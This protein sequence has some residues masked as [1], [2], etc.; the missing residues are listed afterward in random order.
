MFSKNDRCVSDLGTR[1]KDTQVPGS[2][3]IYIFIYPHCPLG[4]L[5]LVSVVASASAPASGTMPRSPGYIS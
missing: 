5:R 1:K 3:Y 2:L 4:D